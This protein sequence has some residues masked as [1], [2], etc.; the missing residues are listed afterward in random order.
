MVSA[1]ATPVRNQLIDALSPTEAAAFI[2]RCE[3]VEMA[4]G[5]VLYAQHDGV[6][7]V[8]F[9]LTGFISQVIAMTDH[10]AME[11][12]LIGNE[13][14]LGA[15]LALDIAIAPF[16]AVVQG[17]GTALRMSA[18]RFRSEM[19][20]CAALRLCVDRYL[21]VTMTQQAQAV[22]CTRFHDIRSRLARWLLMSHDRAH[23]DHFHLTHQYLADM[24]GVRRSGVT[25]AARALHRGRLIRYSRGEIAVID[26]AGL[27]AAA[28]ECYRTDL[29]GY[30]SVMTG[31]GRIARAAL[32]P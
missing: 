25:I 11:L 6:E 21:Y 30:Q 28:C 23:Q 8:Y 10:P 16:A 13:G 7:Q 4:F 26:R 14:M 27:E 15:T 31:S 3:V 9:P 5:D 19:S 20:R 29:A 1:T 2:A 24:L 18:V 32:Q 17:Q 22:V 12:G